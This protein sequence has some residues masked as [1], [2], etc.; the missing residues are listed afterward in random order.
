MKNLQIYAI[1]VS[2]MIILNLIISDAITKLYYS[3][4]SYRRIRTSEVWKLVWHNHRRKI[5][6]LIILWL[7]TSITMVL[8]VLLSFKEILN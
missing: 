4:I 3:Q 6:L 7:I 8:L 2:A 1:A 5:I